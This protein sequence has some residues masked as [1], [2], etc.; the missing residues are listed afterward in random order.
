MKD[1]LATFHRHGVDVEFRSRYGTFRV[2][3]ARKHGFADITTLHVAFEPGAGVPAGTE[4]RLRGLADHIVDRAKSLFLRYSGE[5]VIE[6]TPY[7]EILA[8][9]RESGRIY[10]NGVLANEEERFLFGYNITSLTTAMRSR[11]NRERTNVGRTTYTDRVKAILRSASTDEVLDSLADE[12]A[13]RAS[14]D[15]AEEL[16]WI[17]VAQIALTRLHQ[18]ANVSLI[19]EEELTNRPD[20]D[21]SDSGTRTYG[22]YHFGPPARSPRATNG[23]W[24]AGSAD[25]F[26]LPPRVSR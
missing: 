3:E 21:R 23:R 5:R 12:A 4:V 11:L 13:K 8:R 17:D 24:R 16:N 14:G 25:N 7:G 6:Q 9:Q 20:L 19:T 26:S 18:R 15:Q 2:V 22:R 10:I 1:A